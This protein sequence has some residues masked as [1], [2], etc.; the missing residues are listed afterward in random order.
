MTQVVGSVLMRSQSGIAY[1]VSK[2]LAIFTC[3]TPFFNSFSGRPFE[4]RFIFLNIGNFG[5]K[6]H[7]IPL[8]FDSLLAYYHAP[9]HMS[10]VRIDIKNTYSL[11]KFRG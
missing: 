5:R 7:E 6:E 9:S 4:R 11:S 2:F 1:E 8:D 10:R 3:L